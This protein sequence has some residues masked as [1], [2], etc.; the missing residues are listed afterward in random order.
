[1]Q[2]FYSDC[3]EILPSSDLL[4]VASYKTYIQTN[5]EQLFR[6]MNDRNDGIRLAVGNELL[7]KIQFTNIFMVGCGAIGC[8]LLK[9]FAMINLATGTTDELTG[10]KGTITITDPDHIE[11]S[12]LNR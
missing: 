9:N 8:E 7:K 1:M 12:N 6:P 5:Y 2:L 4:C 11:V 3:M 10:A